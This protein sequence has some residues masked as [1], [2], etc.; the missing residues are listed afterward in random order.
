MHKTPLESVGWWRKAREASLGVPI[1]YTRWRQ[2]RWGRVL[3]ER[4]KAARQSRLGDL[5][6]FQEEN[7]M[8]T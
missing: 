1:V 3:Q 7:E 4:T 8:L 6:R 5:C 2:A